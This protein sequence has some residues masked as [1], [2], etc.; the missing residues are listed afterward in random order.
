MIN[1]SKPR[2]THA[3]ER[4]QL[5]DIRTLSENRQRGPTH[6]RSRILCQYKNEGDRIMDECFV[7]KTVTALQQ[8]LAENENTLQVQL[9]EGY[10]YRATCTFNPPATDEEIMNFEQQTGYVLPRDYRRFLKIT[11][12]CRLF[13]DIK[14]GGEIQLYSL[15]EIRDYHYEEAFEGCFTIASIYQDHLVIKGKEVLQN[16]PHYLYAKGHI[17][18]F[19]AATPLQLNFETWF[20]RFVLCQGA[21]FWLW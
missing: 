9:E 21:K 7:V 1:R 18:Q 2:L 16:E 13:D 15:Q 3:E 19:K 14:Y 11:N 17:D 5:K 6:E 8:R 10:V 4:E 12:G 20:D